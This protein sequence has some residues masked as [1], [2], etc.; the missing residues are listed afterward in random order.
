M[1]ID[2]VR[3][4]TGPGY[5]A[6]SG[7]RAAAGFRLPARAAASPAA[8][9]Q[10]VAMPGMLSLQEVDQPDQRDHAAR[11]RGQELLAE[12]AALQRALL[13]AEADALPAA[14]ARLA[15]LA[16]AVPLAADPALGAAVTA[17]VLRSR[18]ELARHRHDNAASIAS[19]GR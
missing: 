17:I 6:R 11:R 18:V 13:G 14:L 10:G 4:T 3:P 12:L 7:G 5:A 2:A 16:E 1:A 19:S 15:R 8:G 9:V